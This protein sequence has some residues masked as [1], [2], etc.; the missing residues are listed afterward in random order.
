M[1]YDKVRK[2]TPEE[3]NKKIEEGIL[4]SLVYYKYNTSAIPER[5][6]ELEKETDIEKALEANASALSLTGVV[7]SVLFGKKWLMVPAVV[8]GFLLQHAIQ[9]WCPPLTI[10]RKMGYRTRKEIETEKHALKLINGD[11]DEVS[12]GEDNDPEDTLQKVKGS[13]MDTD[14]PIIPTEPP[15][16]SR[17]RKPQES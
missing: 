14:M 16:R 6:E 7:F 17:I 1:Q 13:S 11:Y 15:R 3:E 8:T 10:F 4:K 9:G 2:V 5:L 12:S